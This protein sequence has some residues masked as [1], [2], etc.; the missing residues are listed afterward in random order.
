MRLSDSKN[1]QALRRC[2]LKYSILSPV[3][4]ISLI[5]VV[6][7]FDWL[8][9]TYF[10]YMLISDVR[11][12]VI[13]VL[14]FM[15]PFF[16]TD[17]SRARG[18]KAPQNFCGICKD[19]FI[20]LFIFMS[21]TVISLK[22][23]NP[24]KVDDCEKHTRC[25]QETQA[26]KRKSISVTA[27]ST[28]P[29]SQ[30]VPIATEQEQTVVTKIAPTTSSEIDVSA[31]LIERAHDLAATQKWLE[32]VHHA[33]EMSEVDMKLLTVALSFAVKHQSPIAII[34]ELVAKGAR[35][36]PDLR[37]YVINFSGSSI[38]LAQLVERGISLS[39]PDA[40]GDTALHTATRFTANTEPEDTRKLVE[41][42]VE[43]NLDVNAPNRKG[44]TPLWYMLNK[45]N[46]ASYSSTITLLLDH[47][48]VVSQQHKV[49]LKTLKRQFPAQYQQLKTQVPALF[50][51]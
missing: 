15:C 22:L 46:V 20:A 41:L 44:K 32:F 35:L 17:I 39:L 51:D 27:R 7:L 42:T 21:V 14:A 40:L 18:N 11:L 45:T 1:K 13:Y 9:N 10:V 28:E 29:P 31:S 50:E 38:I 33:V 19:L 48:A 12:Y 43:N 47:G 23:L 49:Q 5:L 8:N 6:S 16:L 2:I 30:H 3:V 34:D 24:I 26:P 36:D 25:T 4:A 37:I